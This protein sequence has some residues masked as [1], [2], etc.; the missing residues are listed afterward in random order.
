REIAQASAHKRHYFVSSRFRTDEVRLVV[1]E[2]QKFVLKR[3]KFEEVVFL[4]NRFRWP[5]AFRTRGAGTDR[6]N[7]QLVVYTVLSRVR[8][9]VDVT[10]VADLSKKRLCAVFV[11]IGCGPNEVV[12]RQTHAVPE[13]PKLG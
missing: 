1:I 8:S 13:R 3:R 9:L 6:I 11:S 7:V 10:V 12:V 4:V 5:A 2:S